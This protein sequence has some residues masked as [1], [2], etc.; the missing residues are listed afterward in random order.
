MRALTCSHVGK[1]LGRT[2]AYSLFAR[3]EQLDELV[4]HRS[5]VLVRFERDER[6]SARGHAHRALGATLE[7]AHEL[8]HRACFCNRRPVLGVLREVA[9]ELGHVLLPHGGARLQHGDRLVDD[10]E[11][12][13]RILKHERLQ[14]VRC[15]LLGLVGRAVEQSDE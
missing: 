14:R 9:Q 15:L 1:R 4:G 10:R 5:S 13:R 7:L 11:L 12:V 8:R 6:Q 3:R 2:L